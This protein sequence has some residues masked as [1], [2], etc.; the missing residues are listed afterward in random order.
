MMKNVYRTAALAAL[1][2]TALVPTVAGAQVTK[3]AMTKLPPAIAP[4][5]G[6]SFGPDSNGI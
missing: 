3:Y 6:Q 5:I 4:D 2:T 1:L